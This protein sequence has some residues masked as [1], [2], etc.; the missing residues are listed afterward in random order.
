MLDIDHFKL[1]ND[2]Y[3]HLAG[4]AC[5]QRLAQ[6][7]CQSGRRA[8]ELIARY[9]GEEFVVL[10]PNADTRAALDTARHMQQTLVMAQVVGR[11]Q[12]P[13][14]LWHNLS[15]KTATT[16]ASSASTVS[17]PPPNTAY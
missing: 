15:M 4:D 8:G 5:L 7:L 10:L 9:G 12:Y 6:A 2:H 11:R 16:P 14:I 3:G 13:Q 17:P 1:F